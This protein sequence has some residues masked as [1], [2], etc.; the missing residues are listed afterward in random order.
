MIL[1]PARAS[2]P[3]TCDLASF[4]AAPPRHAW[5]RLRS[6][7]AGFSDQGGDPPELTERVLGDLG[8]VHRRTAPER[9]A[10]G[11]LADRAAGGGPGFVDTEPLIGVDGGN[12]ERETRFHGRA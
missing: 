8:V 3:A 10:V 6:L 1:V 4:R 12:R 9:T 11:S 7:R 2:S 5:R